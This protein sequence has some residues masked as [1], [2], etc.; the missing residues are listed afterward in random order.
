MKKK[1][2]SYISEYFMTVVLNAVRKK[3]MPFFRFENVILL[4]INFSFRWS[5]NMQLT[6]LSLSYLNLALKGEKTKKMESMTFLAVSILEL[7]V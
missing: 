1:S 2:N 6:R 7:R 4:K 3:K 5:S